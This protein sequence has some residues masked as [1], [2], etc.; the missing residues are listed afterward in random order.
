MNKG[1]QAKEASNRP[2]K[3]TKTQPTSLEKAKQATKRFAAD[4]GNSERTTTISNKKARESHKARLP[5]ANSMKHKDLKAYLLLYGDQSEA[6][7]CELDGRLSDNE[8]R[9]R[10]RSL[11]LTRTLPNLPEYP[12][13]LYPDNTV[14]YHLLE[15]NKIHNFLQARV[16]LTLEMN[17]D[18]SDSNENKAVRSYKNINTTSN[19]AN[20]QQDQESIQQPG[21]P[22]TN[23]DTTLPSV[24]DGTRIEP[25]PKPTPTPDLTRRNSAAPYSTPIHPAVENNSLSYLPHQNPAA[26]THLYPEYLRRSTGGESTPTPD[27]TRRN[28][29]P[30]LSTTVHPAVENNPASHLP[31]QGSAAAVHLYP[32]YLNMPT[33]G[34]TNTKQPNLVDSRSERQLNTTA[35]FNGSASFITAGAAGTRLSQSA[36]APAVDNHQTPQKNANAGPAIQNTAVPLDA[37]QTKSRIPN[38]NKPARQDLHPLT[39]PVQHQPDKQETAQQKSTQSANAANRNMIKKLVTTAIPQSPANSSLSKPGNSVNSGKTTNFSH[40]SQLSGKSAPRN[41][42]SKDPDRITGK[43]VGKLFT[44]DEAL[45]HNSNFSKTRDRVKQ[46]MSNDNRPYKDVALPT[47]EGEVDTNYIRNGDPKYERCRVVVIPNDV[48]PDDIDSTNPHKSTDDDGTSGRLS[49]FG[50]HFSAVTSESPDDTPHYHL[51]AWRSELGHTRK[52]FMV[53]IDKAANGF[54]SPPLKMVARNKIRLLTQE[55]QHEGLFELTPMAGTYPFLLKHSEEIGWHN[56]VQ[57]DFP[58]GGT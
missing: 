6:A 25:T 53:M 15:L 55:P 10:V 20:S 16:K 36:P 3:R 57:S 27:P 11:V 50:P 35:H 23:Y 2:N 56:A 14:D 21:P 33:R 52:Q 31:H 39:D 48:D 41:R 47:M 40:A 24:P 7:I 42:N 32:E 38:Q 29:A 34:G 49:A 19:R 8:L 58:M 17:G 28:S 44:P 54:A 4:T 46:P 51:L 26:G 37:T 5:N 45:L 1:N 12:E 22:I 13:G 18:F 30:P 43:M 9:D